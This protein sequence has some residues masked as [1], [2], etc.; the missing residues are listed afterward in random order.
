M[1]CLVQDGASYHESPMS[2]S[3]LPSL[4]TSAIATP[5]DRN[6]PSIT[7]F[8]HETGVS[9]APPSAAVEAVVRRVAA[10]PRAAVVQ[11]RMSMIV[12]PR[13]RRHETLGPPGSGPVGGPIR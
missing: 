3:S 13:G 6:L 4:L 7:V 12:S 8:F 5:S 11:I 2:T 1:S 9:L 10:R